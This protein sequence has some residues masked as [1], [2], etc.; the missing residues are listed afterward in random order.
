MNLLYKSNI[1]LSFSN[2]T[3]LS[4][5]F[6]ISNLFTII[7]TSWPLWCTVSSS[8]LI[9][10]KVS[11]LFLSFSNCLFSYLIIPREFSAFFYNAVIDTFVLLIP[12][13]AFTYLSYYSILLVFNCNSYFKFSILFSIRLDFLNNVS[14]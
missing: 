1:V 13:S 11:S 9:S 6:S 14:Y 3:F 8:L 7:C 4:S 2:I 5:L 10:Y 12:S